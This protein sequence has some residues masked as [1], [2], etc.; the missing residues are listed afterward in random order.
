[1]EIEPTPSDALE[2]RLVSDFVATGCGCQLWNGC[3]CSLQFSS[4]HFS[5]IR[6]YCSSLS[7]TE[8][9]MALLGQI[10]A[11]SDITIKPGYSLLKQNRVHY[12]LHSPWEANM[13]HYF[14]VFACVGRTRIENLMVH[15]ADHGLVPR[16]HGNLKHLPKHALSFTTIEYVVK[17]L[18]NHAENNAIL[19]PGR[20]PGYKET[21]IKLLPSSTSKRRIWRFYHESVQ[22]INAEHSVA[23]STFNKL[24][25]SLLPSI[26]SMKPMTDLCWI[27][28]KNS[29]AI[30]RAANS[31][32][33]IKAAENHLFLVQLERSFY[34]TTCDS[35]RLMFKVY[36]LLMAFVDLLNPT[37]IFHPI[38]T[39]YQCIT[40]STM[41]NKCITL[42]TLSNQVQFFF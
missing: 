23:Y 29:T 13:L 14:S 30:V 20:I 3:N 16:T 2:G 6:S 11:L 7:H 39:K 40:L 5:D 35:C 10:M 21:D 9:D 15:F 24:W 27:C 17:F 4:E 33:I 28:Q 19:L 36:S 8:L 32:D 31:S 41:H 12:Y 37:A 34:K 22:S 38:P 42:R 26:I 25:K 1:M 18:V